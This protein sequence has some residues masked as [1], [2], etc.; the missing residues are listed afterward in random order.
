MYSSADDSVDLLFLA[1]L[2]PVWSTLRSCACTEVV[3]AAQLS[4]GSLSKSQKKK[5]KKNVAADRK[6]LINDNGVGPS[7]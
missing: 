5:Q 4:A 2:K 3:W 6:A 7:P 1:T